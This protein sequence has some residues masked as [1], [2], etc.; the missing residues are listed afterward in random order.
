MGIQFNQKMTRTIG[1][2]YNITIPINMLTIQTTMKNINMNIMA[3]KESIQKPRG[4]I[5]TDPFAITVSRMRDVRH[6]PQCKNQMNEEIKI[7]LSVV[8]IICIK[9]IVAENGKGT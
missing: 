8:V 1:L 6:C 2:T 9:T 3:W 7:S 4:N 5:L